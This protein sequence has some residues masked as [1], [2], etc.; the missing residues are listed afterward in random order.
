MFKGVEPQRPLLPLCQR[1]EPVGV[2]RGHG[3]ALAHGLRHQ[4][5]GAV[6]V[7]VRQRLLDGLGLVLPRPHV[8][9]DIILDDDWAAATF[10][11]ITSHRQHQRDI[12]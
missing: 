9:L 11:Y 7:A 5:D 8:R 12:A 2:R 10:R 6:G 4:A 1:V 3:Q